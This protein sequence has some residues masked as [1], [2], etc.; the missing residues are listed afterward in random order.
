MGGD[1][2]DVIENKKLKVGPEQKPP[3]LGQ[4]KSYGLIKDKGGNPMGRKKNKDDT[5]IFFLY[6]V[7]RIQL[8]QQVVPQF[9]FECKSIMLNPYVDI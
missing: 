9:S 1:T 2:I 4:D 8:L 3:G 5:R 6:W 7:M